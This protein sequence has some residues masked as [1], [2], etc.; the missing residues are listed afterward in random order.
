MIF[1]CRFLYFVKQ[2]PHII[3]LYWVKQ[4]FCI[5]NTEGFRRSQIFFYC[6]FTSTFLQTFSSDTF[7][8]VFCPLD[9]TAKKEQSSGGAH[10][11][12]FFPGKYNQVSA[13][14]VIILS[15]LSLSKNL[16]HI[17]HVLSCTSA[18]TQ[19]QPHRSPLTKVI[20][21]EPQVPLDT[22]YPENILTPDTRPAHGHI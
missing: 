1:F 18:D 3:S 8:I 5:V 16:M 22:A 17:L 19:T 21:P 6:T 13:W 12:C 20:L 15:F 11:C 4:A 10:Y 2:I 14:S 9:T 7:L